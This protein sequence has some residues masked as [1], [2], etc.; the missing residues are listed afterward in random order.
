MSQ[1]VALTQCGSER[2]CVCVCVGVLHVI[3]VSKDREMDQLLA[4]A[5]YHE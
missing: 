4:K 3:V 1:G 5:G 2:E